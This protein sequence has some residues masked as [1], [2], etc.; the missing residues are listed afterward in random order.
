MTFV[1]GDAGTTRHRLLAC[2]DTRRSHQLVLLREGRSCVRSSYR[3]RLVTVPPQ[4]AVGRMRRSFLTTLVLAIVAIAVVVLVMGSASS[5]PTWK[6]IARWTGS[7]A[8]TP[9][10]ITGLVCHADGGCVAVGNS[11]EGVNNVLLVRLPHSARWRIH[12]LKSSSQ[13]ASVS[14]PTSSMCVANFGST[15]MVTNDGGQRWT[16]R[17]VNVKNFFGYSI[18]CSTVGVC[19]LAGSLKDQ[20][21]ILTSTD[22]VR[23]WSIALRAPSLSKSD[24]SPSVSCQSVMWC[25]AIVNQGIS[26][27]YEF[28]IE[29]RVFRTMNGGRTWQPS[30]GDTEG[31]DLGLVSCT[32]LK[33][34]LASGSLEQPVVGL[35]SVSSIIGSRNGGLDWGPTALP[36]TTNLRSISCVSMVRCVAAGSGQGALGA[37]LLR[38]SATSWTTWLRL[39]DAGGFSE[40][41]CVSASTCFAA[42][43]PGS[44]YAPGGAAIVEVHQ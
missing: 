41:S 20:A 39:Q 13:A 33:D 6:V 34:C 37:V 7:G 17:G 35:G 27:D 44:T 29:S 22:G 2:G 5:G 25:S 3:E 4:S 30:P 36:P 12:A 42:L 16:E 10:N 26:S 18:D 21:T 38:G 23:T 40:V 15:V 28:P 43:Q 24:Y 14:C 9:G 32:F 31:L 1:V 19:M 11:E 8:G